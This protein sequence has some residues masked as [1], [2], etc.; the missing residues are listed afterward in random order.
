MYNIYVQLLINYLKVKE[1]LVT[2]ID[3][4]YFM[5]RVQ[6]LSLI[7]AHL[8]EYNISY[9]GF[10]SFTQSHKKNLQNECLSKKDL[11]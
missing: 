4:I 10:A 3:L 1:G 7:C 8:V 9:R 6:E 11:Y 5:C 2:D